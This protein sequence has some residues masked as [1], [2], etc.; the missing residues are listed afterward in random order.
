M[1]IRKNI[2]TDK[3]DH[4][5]LMLSQTGKG[6]RSGPSLC[7]QEQMR[8]IVKIKRKAVNCL[9]IKQNVINIS[10]QKIERNRAQKFAL[11][12]KKSKCC[13]DLFNQLDNFKDSKG[14]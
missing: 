2:L 6:K 14:F 8:K 11:I 4:T 7:N 13:A 3:L 1:K 10:T 12:L 5:Y 9:G